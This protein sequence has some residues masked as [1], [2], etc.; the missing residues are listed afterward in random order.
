MSLEA[1]TTEMNAGQAVLNA[2]E[3]AGVARARA[4]FKGKHLLIV[5]DSVSRNTFV[6]LVYFLFHGVF[7]NS[8]SPLVMGRLNNLTFIEEFTH[9]FPA[10]RSDCGWDKPEALHPQSSPSRSFYCVMYFR[11]E[12]MDINV[13][14]VTHVAS[15]IG[16]YPIGWGSPSKSRWLDGPESE[17]RYWGGN[18][19]EA[20]HSLREY[21]GQ[22]DTVVV[23]VG[24][25]SNPEYI[26][27]T[28]EHR[29]H[30]HAMF[31]EVER[32]SKT[33]PVWATTT[34]VPSRRVRGDPVALS[35]A[36]SRGWTVLDRRGMT[37]SLYSTFATHPAYAST[38]LWVRGDGVHWD[39]W[40]TREM[41]KVL[42][43]LLEGIWAHL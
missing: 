2:V 43:D 12:A 17:E 4:V 39:W 21:Y 27:H 3:A 35:V 10:V 9:S 29:A 19:G 18:L 8:E 42:L 11:H 25:W 30:L 20:A 15:A 24:L 41:N 31:E 6:S 26:G 36:L 1:C 14:F 32:L 7:P 37:S 23:N 40:V 33:A 16:T 22:V 13:T 34:L 38:N 5:G 28:G